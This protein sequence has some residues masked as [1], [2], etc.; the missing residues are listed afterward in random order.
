VIAGAVCGK[1]GIARGSLMADLV[2]KL[3][4]GPVGWMLTLDDA[5]VGGVYGTKEAAFEAAMVAASFSVR[6]GD[7]VQINVPSDANMRATEKPDPWPKDW[8]A[9]LK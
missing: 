5:R 1:E 6:A 3:L 7:G 9:F 2:Y 8:S 4:K